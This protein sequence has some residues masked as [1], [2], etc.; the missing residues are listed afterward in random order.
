MPVLQQF[1]L[2]ALCISSSAPAR[3]GEW[4]SLVEHLVRDQGVGGSNPLSPTI[5]EIVRNDVA[6]ELLL[7]AADRTGART[8]QLV[9]DEWKSRVFT[10]ACP[11]GILRL[12][13]PRQ[14]KTL[15]YP[16]QLRARPPKKCIAPLP[17]PDAVVARTRLLAVSVDLPT[18]RQC[19]TDKFPWNLRAP[20]Q[21]AREN[22]DAEGLAATGTY[23]RR[24]G[25]GKHTAAPV[26]MPTGQ[27]KTQNRFKTKFSQLIY[28]LGPWGAPQES[29]GSCSPAFRSALPEVLKT[30]TEF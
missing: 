6:T 28:E 14:E 25:I 3:V 12:F 4:L 24:L 21:P 7:R 2:R 30:T 22:C 8:S 5:F 29:D 26:T 17:S 23:R 1:L 16:G 13:G 18:L 27:L 9:E 15:P 10:S 11:V 19:R 20:G